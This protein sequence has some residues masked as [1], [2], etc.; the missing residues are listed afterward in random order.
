MVDL[1][2][3]R[4]RIL[5]HTPALGAERVPVAAAL[6]RV[7]ARDLVAPRDFPEVAVSAM[8]GYAVR[9]AEHGP[10]RP[11]PVAGVVAAGS[12]QQ[13]L[14]PGGVA[15]IFTGA[16][17]PQGADAVIIQE[18][19]TRQGD[20]VTFARASAVG[21]N[22]RPAGRDL[23]A[24]AVALPAG[25][26]LGPGALMLA[27][28]LDAAELTVARRPRVVLL[29]TGD[30]LRAVG[31]AHR[32]GLI[33]ESNGVGVAALGRGA[34]ADVV[35]AARVPDTLHATRDALAD[36]LTVYDVVVTI[37][38]ASVGDRDHV[39]AALAALGTSMDVA[40]VR[41]KPGKPLLHARLGTRRVLGL[42]G[43]P[44][45][46]LVTFALFG[47]PL[48]RALQGDRV[49]VPP[50]FPVRLAA[51][52]A[53]SPDRAVAVQGSV[54]PD[55]FTA[56]SNQTSGAMT[57][58][59]ASDGFVLLPASEQPLPAGALVPFTSWAQL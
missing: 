28:S 49:V 24:G 4:S 48:I 26:R 32:L 20:T 11:W 29:A 37:G 59:A 3:A 36:A 1:E 51:A 35:I 57:A 55:G 23:R 52:T 6:G 18:N 53:S 22:V 34:G 21:E 5:A 47:V 45:S 50:A 10:D 33:V 2:E 54:G 40:K 44:A 15:R 8:D 43:N 12:G 13:V 17:L 56:H 19:A 14:A 38:G 7:L 58:L 42:P 31:E 27:T 16:P 39:R 25:Q 46:A 9:A 30:E 41:L